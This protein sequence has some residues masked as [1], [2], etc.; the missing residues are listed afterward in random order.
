MTTHSSVLAWRIPRTD[1]PGGLQS[2]GLQESQTQPNNMGCRNNRRLRG[3]M[4]SGWQKSEIE[5]SAGLV[6]LE[7]SVPGLLMAAFSLCL[8]GSLAGYSPWGP[9]RVTYNLGPEQQQQMHAKRLVSGSSEDAQ[10]IL[11][12]IITYF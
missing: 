4:K 9:Q 11:I 3:F 10:Q 1:G 12:K 6:F 2:V 8:R 5:V 7:A